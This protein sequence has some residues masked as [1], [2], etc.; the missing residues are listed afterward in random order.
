MFYSDGFQRPVR[1]TKFG[2]A[3]TPNAPQGRDFRDVFQRTDNEYGGL[4][5]REDLINSY[6]DIPKVVEIDL[7]KATLAKLLNVKVPDPAD[8]A[9]LAEKQRLITQYQGKTP[10]EIKELLKQSPPLGRQQYTKN[11][12]TSLAS[13]NISSDEKIK[14]LLQEVKAGRTSTN[15]QM[16]N[17]V[18]QLAAILTAARDLDKL[19]KTPAIQGVVGA[20]PKRIN[21]VSLGID[22]RFLDID[23][24]KKSSGRIALLILQQDQESKVRHLD[25]PVKVQRDIQ[26]PNDISYMKLTTL[27]GL[28]TTQPYF[29][30]LDSSRGVILKNKSFIPDIARDLNVKGIDPKD[31]ASAG[32]FP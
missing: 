29:L 2:K 31:I 6:L 1:K 8:S 12:R 28:K 25:E 21:A 10:D 24:V 11:V 20:I 19:V 15:A 32:L 27:F 30:D 4:Q 18:V 3:N 17:M 23:D 5:T 13:A 9:W 14:E 7:G 16:A 22:L 26:D